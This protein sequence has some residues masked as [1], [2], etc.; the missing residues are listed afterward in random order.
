MPSLTFEQVRLPLALLLLI[1]VAFVLL[2]RGGPDATA[3]PAAEQPPALSAGQPGGAV[4]ATET[5]VPGTPAPT[6]TIA[7]SPTPE[8][9]PETVAAD[10][11]FSAE[12]LA[13][14]SIAGSE[15]TGEL[16]TLPADAASFTAL[17][18]FTDANAGDSIQVVMTG[19]A[20]TVA[21]GPYTMGGGGDGYYYATFN[22]VGLP[23]GEYALTATR[24]GQE[25]AATTF[26]RAG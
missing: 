9:T 12:V 4:L 26:R 22:V 19:P 16:G 23:A 7:P 8:P 15:C 2:P 10:D 11:G 13:C 6:P 24:N 14:R 20:G 21:G 5:P 1:V 18:R 3:E 25:V 17:V